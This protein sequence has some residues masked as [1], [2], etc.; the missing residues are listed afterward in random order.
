MINN[1]SLEVR[2]SGSKLGLPIT[3]TYLPFSGHKSQFPLESVYINS[4]YLINLL[5]RLN[6]II[7]IKH[8]AQ[9]LEYKQSNKW[10]PPDHYIQKVVQIFTFVGLA[11]SY[12]GIYLTEMIRTEH[13]DLCTWTFITTLFIILK[14]CNHKFPT[15]EW[16][17]KWWFIW[18][19]EYHVAIKYH[20]VKEHLIIWE[21]IH[22][23]GQKQ[24]IQQYISIMPIL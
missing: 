20:A 8:L 23:K 9:C 15:I 19:M 22:I 13:K 4:T 1:I 3:L 16:L 12:L 24:V 14:N 18:L 11:I 5:W 17:N 6:E 21:N 10:Y 2:Q 7:F